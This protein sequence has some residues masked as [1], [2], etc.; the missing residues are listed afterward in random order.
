MFDDLSDVINSR[1]RSRVNLAQVKAA[2]FEHFLAYGA[3]VIW[4]VAIRILAIDRSS[5]YPRDG[6]LADAARSGK[7]IRVGDLI[8]VDLAGERS[9]DMFLT[10]H[11][12]ESL[13]P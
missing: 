11:V 2:P 4:F 10:Q 5:E 8:I 1:M 6:G 7:K 3:T 9:D 13:G 12:S